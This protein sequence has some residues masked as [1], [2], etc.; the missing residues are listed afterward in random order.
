MRSRVLIDLAFIVLI[1]CVYMAIVVLV[2]GPEHVLTPPERVDLDSFP[3]IVLG[4]SFLAMLAWYVIGEW[5]IKP[6]AGVGAWYAT[7]LLLLALVAVAAFVVSFYFEP[8]AIKAIQT[9]NDASGTV[10]TAGPSTIPIYPWLNVLGAI[11]FFYLGC[12]LFSPANAK[13]LIW[14][15]KHIR[16]W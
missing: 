3:W 6:H 13:F 14:P 5:G 1:Y 11:G 8:V 15:S 7:W 9:V 16:T 4:S 2:Y 12:V 10:D